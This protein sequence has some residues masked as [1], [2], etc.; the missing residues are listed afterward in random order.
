M[1]ISES[2]GAIINTKEVYI[3]DDFFVSLEYQQN[4]NELILNLKKHYDSSQKYVI[5][6]IGVIGF[7]ITSCNFWGYSE[8]VLDFEYVISDERIIIP[9]LKKK[10]IDVP[11]I[12]TDVDILYSNHIET[13]ITFSSGDELRVA[14][15]S[16]EII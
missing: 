6:F 7:D 4:R 16:I 1:I 15:E 8:C 5:R 13:L 11:N 2:N 9:K 3:H 14:C 10:W 12:S